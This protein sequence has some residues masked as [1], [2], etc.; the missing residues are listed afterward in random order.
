MTAAQD[1]MA[2][3]RETRLLAI[4]RGADRAASVATALALVEEGVRALEISLSGHEPL[5]V[6]EEVAARTA[7]R[8]AVGAGTVLTPAQVDAAV[9]AG[10]RFVVTPAVAGSVPHAVA[11]GLPVLCGALTPTEVATAVGHGATAVKIFPASTVGP[12]Y[13]DA[14]AGPFPGLDTVPVGGIGKDQAVEYLAHGACAVGVA[15]PLCGDAPDGGDL[16]AL[17]HRTRAFLQAVQ[18]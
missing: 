17:R 14:L 13:L 11:A 6:I 18:P 4:V 16:A 2:T 9:A 8:A 12:G 1:L 15:G 5:A 7:G 10:A 3:L